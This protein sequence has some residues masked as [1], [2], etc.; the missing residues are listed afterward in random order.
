MSEQITLT[1]LELEA[2]KTITYSD[3]YENGR[4]SILWDY[5]VYEICDIPASKRGGVYGS[6]EKK[7]LVQIQQPERKYLV[8]ENGNKTLNKW[9]SRDGMNFGTI[10]ITPLGYETLDNL[11][12]IDEHGSFINR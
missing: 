3:F 8:D 9:W 12:L 11:N 6:L 5:S 7:G 1:E 4:E 2:L 10:L